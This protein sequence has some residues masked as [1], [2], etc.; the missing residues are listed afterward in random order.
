MM[1][2]VEKTKRN[3]LISVF[4]GIAIIVVQ[5]RTEK[6]YLSHTIVR[7]S[8]TVEAIQQIRFEVDARISLII[9]DFEAFFR[10]FAIFLTSLSHLSFS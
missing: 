6:G 7:K 8:R 10:L 1:D 3:G 9:I 2:F 4:N 5:T